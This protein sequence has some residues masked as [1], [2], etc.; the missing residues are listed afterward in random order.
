MI[1]AA[2]RGIAGGSRIELA[3]KGSHRGE[4][5]KKRNHESHLSQVREHQNK[6]GFEKRMCRRHL[7]KEK[8]QAMLPH[9]PV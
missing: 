5:V 1:V 8:A 4:G 3:H 7:R 2:V 6:T 9:R